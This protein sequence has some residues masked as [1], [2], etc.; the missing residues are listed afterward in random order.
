[1]ERKERS[2]KIDRTLSQGARDMPVI[3][4][5]GSRAE[6]PSHM[7]TQP[8]ERRLSLHG[9]KGGLKR[10]DS[11]D[12]KDKEAKEG[13]ARSGS[14]TLKERSGSLSLQREKGDKAFVQ[15]EKR[16]G[17]PLDLAKSLNQMP[18]V[19]KARGKRGKNEE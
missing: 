4:R 6:P 12:G 18:I 1:L 9:D 5:K 7:V 11:D 16:K 3:G 8:K 17:V 19:H 2:P 15:K 14:V 10:K 13:K